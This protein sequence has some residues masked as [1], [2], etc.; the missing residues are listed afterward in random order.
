[1]SRLEPGTN[2][3]QAQAAATIDLQKLARRKAAVANANAERLRRRTLQLTPARTGYSLLRGQYRQPL[4][5]LMAA[6][7]LLLLIACA[8]VATLLVARATARAREIAIRMAIGASRARLVRQLITESLLLG[9]IGGAC[10][11][12]VCVYLGTHASRVPACQCRSVAVFTR[13]PRSLRS[14]C[15]SR[16]RAGSSSV[17]LLFC[18][19]RATTASTAL[20][21]GA[22]LLSAGRLLDLRGVLVVVQVALSILLVVGAGLFAR[23]LQNLRA[24]DMGFDREHILLV[25]VDP[26]RSGYARQRTVVFFDQLLQRAACQARPG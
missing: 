17:S 15:S 16:W 6:V 5:I 19:R 10:G 3:E 25:S 18:K 13:P 21:S 8:N 2:L 4:L 20:K 26:A 11:W 23:T 1:M 9:V 14:R 22:G 24:V 12:I 7:I